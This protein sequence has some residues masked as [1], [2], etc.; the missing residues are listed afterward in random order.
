MTT[1]TDLQLIKVDP[2]ALAVRDQAREDATP[3]E[4]LI[5]SV[6]QHGIIQPPVV[7]EHDG[8]YVI[9]TG[10]RRVGAAIAAGIAEISVI[11][12][13]TPLDGEAITLEQQIVENERRKQLSA[14][15]LAAGY[16]RLTLF[17]LRPE[18]IAAGLGEKPERIRAGLRVT[19]SEKA[20]D[21]V[22]QEPTIDLE[23]AAIIAEFDEHPKLQ[24]KLIETAT[25]RPKNFDRD[26]ADARSKREV[27]ARVTKLKEQLVAEN[28]DVVEIL[29]YGSEWWTGKGASPGTGKTLERLGIEPAAH[30]TCPG[31]AAIIEKA[32]SYY[33]H[34]Q[35]D[36]WIRYVCT[37]WETNGHTLTSTVHVR[38]KTPEELEREAEWQRQQQER[39]ERQ[40]L[41]DT[42]TDVRRTWIH[43]HLTTRRLRPVAAH[44][45]LLAAALRAEIHHEDAPDPRLTLQLIDGT[46][47]PRNMT[48]QE[49]NALAD[50]LVEVVES[51]RVPSLRIALARA[52]A[53]FEDRGHFDGAAAVKYWDA[54]EALDYTLTDTDKDHRADALVAQTE[55]FADRA[56]EDLT[57]DAADDENEPEVDE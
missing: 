11:L 32:A 15:D 45:D 53:Y 51:G 22:A 44:F 3:D 48:W 56:G 8:G 46:A 20:A 52:F 27:D 14:R 35:P 12:R 24:Q 26:T 34:E 21:L 47:R 57:G 31:H 6:L 5:A 25:T 9:V 4:Q 43:T 2:A 18:D 33:L 38:E 39:R 40:A 55:W 29:T 23:R 1:T 54:L 41:I 28:V 10:H 30:T 16:Q 37:D 13:P 36:D 50:E 19:A 7:E 17:G 42:N 49:Q